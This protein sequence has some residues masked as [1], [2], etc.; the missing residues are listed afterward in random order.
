[1]PTQDAE[2]QASARTCRLID[3]HVHPWKP[4][5][6]SYP[7]RQGLSPE[8]LIDRMN[9]EGV[10]RSVL[11]PEESPE[12]T[13]YILTRE[14]VEIRDMYPERFIAFV[15]IDPRQTRMAER[16]AACVEKCDCRGFGELKNGLLFD[17]PLNEAIYEICDHLGLPIVFHC[18]MRL[19]RDEAGLPRLEAMAAKYP[20]AIFVG[21]GPGFWSAISADDDRSENYPDGPIKSGGA[22]DRLFAEYPNVY[23]E[24]SA[25]SGLRAMTRDPDFT[26]GFLQRNHAKL[27]FGTDFISPGQKLG[28][29][30]WLATLDIPIEWR[31]EMAYRNAERVLGVAQEQ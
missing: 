1:M 12:C 31:Q 10:D 30:E 8:Q 16:V 27:I 15:S 23:G 6:W 21:H 13:E 28:Q 24:F 7:E 29:F 20:Q 22:L 18:D 11:L 9:R 2:K 25:G 19:C 17:D 4:Q 5:V 26:H 14:V 3:F